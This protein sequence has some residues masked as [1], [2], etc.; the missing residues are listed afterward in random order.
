MNAL[1]PLPLWGGLAALGIAVP[2]L[3]HLLNKARPRKLPWAAMELLQRTSQQR[4]RKIKLEDLFIMALRCL[5][6]LLAALAMMRLV[7]TNDGSFFSGAPRELIL[8]V[9][10]SYSMNHGQFESRIDLAKKRAVEAVE[11]LPVGSKLSLVTLGRE[12]EVLFRHSDPDLDTL[13]R[14]LDSME[15]HPSRLSLDTALSSIG[16]LLDES[17]LANKEVLFLTDGQHASWE[18]LPRATLDRFAE[19]QKVAAISVVPLS[20]GSSENLSVSGLHVVSGVRRAGG[21]ASLSAT[22]TNHGQRPAST[23]L[24]LTHNGQ[25][26]DVLQV[27]PIEPGEGQLVRLGSQ[28]EDAG[29]NRFEVS[30]DP[31]NLP[32]DNATYL[33][34]EVPEKLK[35]LIIEGRNRE[36]R[37]LELALRLQRSGYSHGL[38]PTI[39]PSSSV[40]AGDIEGADVIILANV[41]DLPDESI[42]SLGEQVRLGAG[43][44]VYAGDQMDAFA[45]ERMLGNLMP[46]TFGASVDPEAGEAHQLR[47][48]AQSH[49][50]S[51]ELG[52]LEAE[53]SD[54]IVRGYHELEPATQANVLLNLSNGNPLLLT[55]AAGKGKVAF[56][57]TGPG[58]SWSTL[59]LNPAGPIL[60]HLLLD[61]LSSG[62]TQRSFKVGESLAVEVPAGSLGAEPKLLHPGGQTSVPRREEGLQ[63][64][65]GI[66][67][68]LGVATEPG[69]YELDSGSNTDFEVLAVNVDP[70]ESAIRPAS[71]E[72]LKAELQGTGVRIAGEEGDGEGTQRQTLLGSYLALAALLIMILQAALST[73]LTR[74]KQQRSAPIRTGFGVGVKAD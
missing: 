71:I 9:D 18:A 13:K 14:R 2:I 58:R 34:I 72:E 73:E 54:C 36:A 53:L 24:L 15:V 56:F 7:F 50:I 23:S 20:D 28:L 49:R 47:V 43:L 65:N 19:L 6:L 8:A 10:A 41:G 59:P 62:G 48:S 52:R 29:P 4:S 5:A 35:V 57:A 45:A 25:G 32:E 38:N 22:V 51:R 40:G 46:L 68:S 1:N 64:D 70:Q 42:E 26:V 31:D 33:A 37:Y 55:Q 21:F 69:F 63:D 17:D 11:N 12:P 27:G 67:L 60:F 16:Y 44:L 3:V 61:E 74:R 39:L 66:Q 30:I